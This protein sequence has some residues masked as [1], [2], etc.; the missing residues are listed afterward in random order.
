LDAMVVACGC[1]EDLSFFCLLLSRL[2]SFWM[3]WRTKK[4]HSKIPYS[5]LV[6]AQQTSSRT[7]L[8]VMSELFSLS[9]HKDRHHISQEPY[10]IS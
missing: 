6:R 1:L 4:T 8:V 5:E 9:C 2:W 3:Q 7:Y 10:H